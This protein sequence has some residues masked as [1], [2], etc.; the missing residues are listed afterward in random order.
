MMYTVIILVAFLA[1]MLTF[2]S[3]FGLG[4][5]LLPAFAL[6]FPAHEAIA[7][8]ALVH[9]MN[10]IFKFSLTFRNIDR[11][12]L[13]QFGIPSLLAAFGGALLL[14]SL[15]SAHPVF[16]YHMLEKIFS[17]TWLNLV[18]GLLMIVF[19]LFEIV[20]ALSKLE[21]DKKYLSLGGIL[22]GF[23]GGL[24]GHQGALRSAFLVKAGL[25]KE[26]FISTGISIACLVDV[27]RLVIYGIH[28]KSFTNNHTLIIAIAVLAAFCGAYIGNKTLKKLTLDWVQKIVAIMLILIAVLMIGGII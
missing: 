4:T 6:F 19:A 20:P 17:V 3:G 24:S 10:N 25:T 21:F 26:V 14:K 28:T 5:L 7:M 13:L 9:F 27:S 16:E 22:S 23:F 15:G 2:F 1:S 18:I 8:T 11:K 12:V